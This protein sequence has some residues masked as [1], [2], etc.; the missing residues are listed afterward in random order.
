MDRRRVSNLAEMQFTP[1]QQGNI[2][3]MTLTD[4][5]G[6]EGSYFINENAIGTL[7]HYVLSHATATWQA[8]PGS[9]IEAVAS[10]VGLLPDHQNVSIVPVNDTDSAVKFNMGKIELAF[11]IPGL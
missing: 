4:A 11:R 1:T 6:R 7:L 5:N 2:S 9:A 8:R 10:I 3:K